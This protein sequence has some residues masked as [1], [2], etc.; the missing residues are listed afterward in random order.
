MSAQWLGNAAFLCKITCL[1]G[2][3]MY[4]DLSPRVTVSAEF[5]PFWFNSK[6]QSY[7]LHLS[8]NVSYYCT[9]S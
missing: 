5:H 4:L 2:F 7:T 9:S 8:V 1:R 6:L 3:V